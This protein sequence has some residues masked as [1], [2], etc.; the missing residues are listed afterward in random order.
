MNGAAIGNLFG[1]NFQSAPRLDYDFARRK[2]LIKTAPAL[3]AA[4]KPA[5]DARRLTQQP[6]KLCT[7]NRSIDSNPEQTLNAHKTL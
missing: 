6:S 2:H 3:N 4:Q 1:G 7:L 5:H